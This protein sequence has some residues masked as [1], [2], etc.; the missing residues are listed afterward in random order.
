M[1]GTGIRKA[2]Y[3]ILNSYSM[4]VNIYLNKITAGILIVSVGLIIVSAWLPATNST[5]RFGSV[6]IGSGLVWFAV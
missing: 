5:L 4:F 1:K 3:V 6:I 2:E